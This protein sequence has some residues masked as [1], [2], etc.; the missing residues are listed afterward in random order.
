MRLRFI[1]CASFSLLPLYLFG[2]FLPLPTFYVPLW[3]CKRVGHKKSVGLSGALEKSLGTKS[4]GV[5]FDWCCFSEL[6]V[7]VGR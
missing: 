6:S 3:G 1:D 5:I 2:E 4:W 7:L